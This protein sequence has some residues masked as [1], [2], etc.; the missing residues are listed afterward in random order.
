MLRSLLKEKV[1]PGQPPCCGHAKIQS[2]RR[3][4]EILFGGW[5]GSSL[6]KQVPKKKL[7]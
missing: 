2:M 6:Y 4:A 1:L 7:C 5:I 3:G